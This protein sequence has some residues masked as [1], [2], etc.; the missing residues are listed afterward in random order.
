MAKTLTDYLNAYYNAAVLHKG[1][2]EAV[3]VE[4]RE[5]MKDDQALRDAAQA[6]LAECNGV[7]SARPGADHVSKVYAEFLSRIDAP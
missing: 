3:I 7:L 5:A 1:N 4:T 6:K 2:T